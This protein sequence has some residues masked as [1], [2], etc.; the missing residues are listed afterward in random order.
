METCPRILCRGKIIF[1]LQNSYQNSD[2]LKNCAWRKL[3]S[4]LFTICFINESENYLG[5]IFSPSEKQH[6]NYLHNFEF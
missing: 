4:K 6:T 1:T 3:E 5:V 2:F